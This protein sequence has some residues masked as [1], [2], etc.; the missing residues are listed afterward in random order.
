MEASESLSLSSFPA[1]AWE[2]F[3]FSTAS[4]ITS[5]FFL[6]ASPVSKK[7]SRSSTCFFKA[8]P[9][10][11]DGSSEKQSILQAI[12]ALLAKN[13]EIR[14][15]FLLA[16]RPIKVEWKIKPYFG[17]FPRFLR[18]LNKAFSAPK[19]WTVEAGYLAKLVNEPACDINLAP[20]ISPIKAARFG[21]TADI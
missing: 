21:A 11:L 15:L 14:P 17:V 5:I 12:E 18:A 2:A 3:K 7:V 1:S 13:R 9:T 20:T 6:G 16:A 4:F 8:E 19:I 10:M